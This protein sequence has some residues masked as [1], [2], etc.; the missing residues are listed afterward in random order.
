MSHPHSQ[1][2]SDTIKSFDTNKADGLAS[3]DV[4]ERLQQYGKNTFPRTSAKTSRLGIFFSQF[5]SALMIILIGAGVISG[6]LHEFIDMTV[7][8]ITAGV[9]VVIGFIQESKADEALKKLRSMVSYKTLVRRDG[10]TIHIDTAELVPGD[11][12]LLEAG[13]KI[14]ADARLI[15]STGLEVNESALTGESESIKKTTKK[16]SEDTSLGDRTNM[17]HRG[18]IVTN[19]RGRAIVTATGVQTEIGKIAQLVTETTDDKTPLQVQLGKM[20]T[21]ISII[22]VCIAAFIFV[23]GSISGTESWFVLFETAVA[24]AVAAIP[25]GLVIS[26]TVIL[27]IGMRFILQKNALVR[28]LVAT[29]TLGSVSVICTD[30]TGTI[31]E[32]N[33]AVTRIVTL[34]S[35]EEMAE[36]RAMS[37]EK[38]SG[39]DA[40]MLGLKIGVIAN[41]G[42]LENPEAAATSWNFVGDT[43]DTAIIA[44]GMHLGKPKAELDTV[45]PHI[46][47]IPFTSEEKYM[48]A[49]TQEG[50]SYTINVKGA[51]EVLLERSTHVFAGGK[52]TSLNK[53]KK[54]VLLRTLSSLSE[55]GLRVIAV[56]YR[57]IDKKTTLT[58][59]D[60]ADLTFVC[61]IA[62]ADPLRTDVVD[63]L[64]MT[65]R[66]GIKTI[67]IT[68]DHIK[69]AAAIAE[70][71]GLP[72]G[73]EH[74]FE[75][76]ALE[77]MTD[78][79]LQEAVKHVSVFARV[80]P[81]HKIRIVRAL[82]ANG[83]VVAM[84][85]DGVNDAPAIKGA[86][87]GVALGSGT[88]VAKETADLVLL[89]DAFSTIVA[90]VEE[91]RTIYQNIKKVVLYLLG[92]SFASTVLITGSI[93][94][95]YPLAALPAQILW[96]NI[97]EDVLP[98]FALAFDK[99]EKENMQDAP[100]KKGEHLIDSEMRS[101]IIAKSVLANVIL[102]S[103]FVYFWKTTGDIKLTRT[104]VFVGLGIDALFFVFS[105]RSLRHYVWQMNPFDNKY[106][107]LSVAA[108]W[109]MLITAVHASPLQYLL[110][111]V[112]LS[113]GQWGI[114]VA[115]GIANMV[116]IETV[117]AIFIHKKPLAVTS[118]S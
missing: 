33:M 116:I 28:K 43:T 113:L 10:K 23:V 22:I 69:T 47:E 8:L 4:A 115:F 84:T 73:E 7:I 1:A 2:I 93:L 91:G 82:Q 17:V 50:D 68:G 87:I 76:S 67:M 74:M 104:I 34:E 59:S 101:M 58:D 19:G 5:K 45:F 102:F 29:E 14:Q 110:R 90:S 53:T 63:T 41:D 75:G 26:L 11:I 52:A 32:G 40:M 18:T 30:K 109:V 66:A 94:L 20:S 108:G 98:V 9:N 16:L 46:S 60:V 112:D 80:D 3:P 36:L 96:I 37:E 111:T 31:T 100:R 72:S 15:Q 65:R 48:A 13:D 64:E 57:E 78:D 6:L 117:K 38:L 97:V 54:D 88:D 44:A 81:I 51:P 62:L 35:D 103:L 61:F 114:M 55:S 83:E 105:I 21:V 25:E 71:V 77:D 24:V 118:N 95:G 99:G 70:Q 42:V 12:L 56:A 86:D 79:E 106:L 89:D 92:G 49:L 27:A 39:Y 85:G 107:V